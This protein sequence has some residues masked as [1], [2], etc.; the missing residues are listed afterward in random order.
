MTIP[1]IHG[2]I[3]NAMGKLDPWKGLGKDCP[4]R[5]QYTAKRRDLKTYVRL[6]FAFV[7]KTLARSKI[8]NAKNKLQFSSKRELVGERVPKR[9]D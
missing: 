9:K 7:S 2:S 5:F 1:F 6:F 3:Q 4:L 8:K